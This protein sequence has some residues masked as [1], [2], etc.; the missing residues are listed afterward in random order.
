MRLPFM[1]RKDTAIAV[2]FIE[3]MPHL[4][5]VPKGEV[6]GHPR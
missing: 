1:N 3:N 6:Q 5:S 2:R 4:S